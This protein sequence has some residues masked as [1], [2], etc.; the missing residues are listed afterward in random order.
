[1]Q[2][3]KLNLIPGG[4][5]PVVNVSQYDVGR[6][7]AIQVYDGA[8]SYNLMGKSVQI[9]GTKPD[10]NGFAYDAQD[11]V[12]SV[13]GNTVT[14]ST[15]QQMT[16]VGGQT[17]AE[18][19]IT[20]GDTILGTI[21][22]ILD[23][24]YSALSDDTPI[25]DTDI[26]AIERDF[27]AALE[28]AQTAAETATTQAGIATT[29]AGEAATSATNAGN[30]ATT[31]GNAATTATT[32]A[33][34]ASTSAT[35]AGNSATAAAADSLEAEGWATGEQ[36]GTPVGPDSPYYQNNAAY[37]AAQAG[38]Y[39]TGGLIFKG[40]VAF[41]NIPTTGMV[42]G[43]MYN[44]TD[45]FTTDSR[46]IEGAGVAVKAGADIA[47]VAGSVN[48]WDILAL[49]GGGGAD[50]LDDLTDVSITSAAD[51][52]LLQRNGNGEWVNSAKIPQKVA[53]LQKTG[54]VNVLRN[55]AR[56]QVV[57]GITYTVS[58]DGIITAN[59]TQTGGNG[60]IEVNTTQW[61]KK[62][63][64]KLIGCPNN[65]G[66]CSLRISAGFDQYVTDTGNGAVVS[67][68]NDGT[69]AIYCY[70]QVPNGTTLNNAVFK[71]MLTPD[72][73]ATYDDY[74]PYSMTNR[75]LTEALY[76]SNGGSS[77]V[78]ETFTNTY[79]Y[80]IPADGYYFL[81]L[82]QESATAGITLAIYLNSAVNTNFLGVYITVGVAFE[83][84]TTLVPLK[85]GAK[86]IFKSN[87]TTLNK[88]AIIA[89]MA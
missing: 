36:N 79:E 26:P 77:R 14:I 39:A 18:L 66:G 68:A 23:V 71:P 65:A 28:Q 35:N 8:A 53:G 7:F 1:M 57:G 89:K 16:A 42:N 51:G 25:S 17:V 54:C 47:F 70:I 33:G 64:Y 82:Q 13:S 74:Q 6:Q 12:V 22:F 32:K 27:E 11:G 31:A 62:G 73:S 83:T 63:V 3:I 76:L 38:Q 10:G 85:Q 21:N 60:G 58:E 43:D 15:T 52:D 59:G 87:N 4:V 46:F 37:Y 67:L 88:S 61:F 2:T 80:T 44:I 78:V 69:R 56:A 86:I 34:E 30:S 24:E 72:L 40:S 81:E 50:A 48:K 19:R 49:G 20:S 45:D 5:L 29:K 9:R 41:A 55:E 75:E 84:L